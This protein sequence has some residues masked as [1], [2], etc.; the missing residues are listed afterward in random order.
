MH[1]MQQPCTTQSEKNRRCKSC[2]DKHSALLVSC[3]LRIWLRCGCVMHAIGWHPGAPR[4]V[5]KMSLKADYVMFIIWL[6]HLHANTVQELLDR[7][8]MSGHRVLAKGVG[9]RYACVQVALNTYLTMREFVAYAFQSLADYVFVVTKLLH[10]PSD[11]ISDVA[12]SDQ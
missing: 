6:C 5:P 8:S 12:Q 7:V 3:R 4:I 11:N 10:K 1:L 9:A 2:I